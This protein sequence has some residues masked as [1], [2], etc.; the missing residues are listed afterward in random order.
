MSADVHEIPT[1]PSFTPQ[2][3]AMVT[4]EGE[5]DDEAGER[6]T[7]PSVPHAEPFVPDA[8]RFFLDG[9]EGRASTAGDDGC[10]DEHEH[11]HEG[12]A[13][14]REQRRRSYVRFVAA[15]VVACVALLALASSPIFP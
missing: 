2:S 5:D 6:P 8:V 4:G 7:L 3:I 11:E 10:D 14:W 1:V 12:M 9:E 13:W 15:T